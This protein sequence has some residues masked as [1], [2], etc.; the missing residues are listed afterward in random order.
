M[1]VHLDLDSE[2]RVCVCVCVRV[3]VC[4][5]V[6]VDVVNA[7]TTVD[8]DSAVQFNGYNISVCVR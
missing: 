8:L 1:V 7:F 3:Y 5:C 2:E 4:G 6:C